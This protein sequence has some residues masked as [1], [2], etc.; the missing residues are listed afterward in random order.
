MKNILSI[1]VIFA[2]LFSTSCNGVMDYVVEVESDFVLPVESTT[3]FNNYST[4]YIDL[5]YSQG[6]TSL[7]FHVTVQDVNYGTESANI[8]GGLS[9]DAQ[10]V[11]YDAMFNGLTA[12]FFVNSESLYI[13]IGF[14][15][16]NQWAVYSITY[17]EAND[18][19]RIANH[20]SENIVYFDDKEDYQVH[21]GT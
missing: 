18:G 9:A 3:V 17:Y 8:L 20:D 7:T 2:L 1:I 15:V 12:N 4:Q 10:S 16:N 11:N 14:Q 13:Q 21:I 6:N 5:N 19:S